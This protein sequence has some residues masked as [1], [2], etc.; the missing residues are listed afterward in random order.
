MRLTA[1]APLALSGL[2]VSAC[3]A[4]G[5]QST[6]EIGELYGQMTERD[7]DLAAATL[8]QTLE[9]RGNGQAGS[10][11]NQESGHS[12]SIQPVETFQTDQGVYCRRY[13]ETLSV[14]G[15]TDSYRQTACRNDDGRWVWIR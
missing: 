13:R 15:A 7:I 8:Q 6:A 9:N 14:A 5:V 10:W 2:L 12:G 11:T 1:F 3:V 4:T